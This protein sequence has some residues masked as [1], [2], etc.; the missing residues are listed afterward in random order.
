MI[1][2][3]S[4]KVEPLKGPN[5]LLIISFKSGQK[6]LVAYQGDLSKVMGGHLLKEPNGFSIKDIIQII[7][8]SFISHWDPL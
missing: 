4:F 2:L 7:P 5:G 6:D 1:F 3:S 8:M